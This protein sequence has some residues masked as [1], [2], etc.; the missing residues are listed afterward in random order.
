MDEG[1]ILDTMR[2]ALYAVVMASLPPLL[3]GLI[4]GIMASIFQAV[5]SIQE[6]TLAFIPKILAV[7]ISLLFF[8]PFMA[9]TLKDFLLSIVSQLPAILH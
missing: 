1:V 4:I 8:G 2:Q 3:C 7:M 5:T 9:A 6:Q